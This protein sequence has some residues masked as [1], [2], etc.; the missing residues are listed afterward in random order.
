[1]A[2]HPRDSVLVTGGSGLVGRAIAEELNRDDHMRSKY[3]WIFVSS[4]D[5]DLTNLSE[6]QSLFQRC[7][8]KYVINLAAR[9]GG[10][11]A[12]IRNNQTFC[13]INTAINE[14]LLRCAYEAKVLRCISFLSTCIFPAEVEYPLDETK[15]S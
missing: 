4:R 10:L 8:P 14:N 13:D 6:T 3:N 2:D 11:Y 15:V 7:K 12:N 1:M 5:A 9:V